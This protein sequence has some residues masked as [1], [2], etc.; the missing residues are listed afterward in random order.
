MG[1]YCMGRNMRSHTPPHMKRSMRIVLP[2]SIYPKPPG[3]L[4]EQGHE[5]HREQPEDQL[6]EQNQDQS[7]DQTD[8]SARARRTIINTEINR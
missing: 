3:S 8:I 4:Q 2:L 6:R 5:H 1:R 7:E